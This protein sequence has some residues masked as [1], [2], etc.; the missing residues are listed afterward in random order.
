MVEMQGRVLINSILKGVESERL[1]PSVGHWH[2]LWAKNW[3][4]RQ[5]VKVEVWF[6]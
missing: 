3:V 2:E 5:E 6:G 1:S 4:R